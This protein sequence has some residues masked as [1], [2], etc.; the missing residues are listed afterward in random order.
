M[1]WAS[2]TGALRRCAATSF[3]GR[4]QTLGSPD[5]PYQQWG[6]RGQERPGAIRL[7]RVRGDGGK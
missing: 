6:A 1:R 3:H 7:Q 5:F 4:D 2:T